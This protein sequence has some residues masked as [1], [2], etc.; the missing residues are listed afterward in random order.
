MIAS[1]G[2]L[3]PPQCS[4]PQPVPKRPRHDRDLVEHMWVILWTGAQ[5]LDVL[6]GAQMAAHEVLGV[7]AVAMLR[8]QGAM[9]EVSSWESV[10]EGVLREMARRV[11]ED[12]SD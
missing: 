1:D 10:V 8:Q 6:R 11:E 4:L 12:G 5:R 3:P 9:R 2:P 7:M